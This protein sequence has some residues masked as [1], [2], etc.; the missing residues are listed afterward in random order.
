PAL[1]LPTDRMRPAI[2]THRGAAVK[3]MLPADLTLALRELSRREGA[4]MF[5]L[6]LAGFALLLSRLAAQDEVVVGSP[7][8]GRRRVETEGLIGLFLNTLVLRT[9]LAGDPTFR[10]LLGRVK[11]VVLGAYRYQELPFEKLLEEL[12]PERQLS[13]SPFFQVLFNMVSVP[14]GRLELPGLKI[15]SL[16]IPEPDSKFD[17]TFYLQEAGDAV[18][19]SVVYN[20]DLFDAVRMEEVVRQFEYVLAQGVANPDERIGAFSLVTTA[21]AAA[22]PDP[23]LPQSDEWMGAVHQGLSRS[24][25][26][27]PGRPAVVGFRDGEVWSYREL[28]VRSNQLAWFLR[29]QGLETG[30]VVAIWAHRGASLPW[31]VMGALKAGGTFMILD[32]AYPATR[33]I[34]YLRIGRPKA[35]LAVEGAPP[36]PPEVEDVL[37]GLSCDVR[38]PLPPLGRAVA[39]GALAGQPTTDPE[40]SVGPDNAAVLT[41]TSGST[42]KPKG[43]IGR[44]GPLSHF[45]P[46]MG[47]RFGLSEADRIGMLSALSHDPLQRDVFTPLWFGATLAVPDPEKIGTHGYLAGWVRSAGV[48]VL[49]LTPAMMEMVTISAEDRPPGEREMPTLRLTFVVGDQLKKSDVERLQ[50]LAPALSCV[51]LYGSTETQRSVSFFPVPRPESPAW[52][53]IGRE[54]LPLGKGMEDVQLLVLNG[55]R[56]LAGV[57]EA[58]EIYIRSQHLARGYL[59]DEALTAERFLTNPFAQPGSGAGDRIYRT[60][61]L[62]RYLPDGTVEFAGRADFQVK[63]RGFRIELGEVE[64]ALSRFP[65]VKECV[66]VVR[67]DR[68]GDRRLAAYLVAETA[69]AAR[70]L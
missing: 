41:F 35:L 51:N 27:F 30:D 53:G 42:G 10:E 7:S 11:T 45:Y 43:V 19:V 58:G 36:L 55:T 16:P 39:E 31:A 28:D 62:G 54:V 8:A 59:G 32:P 17:F 23:A 37:L 44:H 65:G 68:P 5:M 61:D 6:L 40:V 2:Q 69:P 50:R 1:E 63:I 34:D 24:A 57:G 13:R 48:T 12:Q 67:E 66:V 25:E 64:A 38:L 52:A 33:L 70:D 20:A 9:N 14:E 21:A 4:S 29:S 49:H 46:W 60:G 26:R 56:R 15:E 3:T 47:R 22:L 18:H